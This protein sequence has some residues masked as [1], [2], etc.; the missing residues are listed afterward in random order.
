[1]DMDVQP[2]ADALMTSMWADWGA[3]TELLIRFVLNTAV[4]ALI[5]RVFYYPKSKRRDYFFTFILI[6]ISV[7]LLIF[8]M[9]GVKLK[10]GFALGLFAIF[11]IIRYRT[12]SVPIREMTYLFLIIAVSAINGLATSISYVELLATNLL[13]ILSIWIC[14]S[15]RYVKHVA[16]KL[17]LYDNIR[18]IT[19]E[20][21][22]EL[23]EDLKKRTGLNI[24]RVEV[25]AIDFSKDTAMV[26]VYYEPLSNEINSVD[27]VGRLPK[28]G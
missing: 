19:P 27:N 11:G 3:L 16:S 22:E 8:L 9:G 6:S 4:I 18:L 17:V 12:E 21:E 13:F 7:F 25:G 28:M 5:V 14:E 20:H 24:L 1:M 10:I 2:L 23:I 26:K 15:N